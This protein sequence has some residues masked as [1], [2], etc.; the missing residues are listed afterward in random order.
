MTVYAVERGTP[1]IHWTLLV[2]AFVCVAVMLYIS[3]KED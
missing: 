1:W 3:L 2:I